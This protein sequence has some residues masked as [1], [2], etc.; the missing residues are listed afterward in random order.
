VAQRKP[1][2]QTGYM[3]VGSNIAYHTVQLPHSKEEIEQWIL[4]HALAAA[5]AASVDPYRLISPPVR[6]PEA[7]FDFTLRTVAGTEYLDLQEIVVLPKDACGYEDGRPVYDAEAMAEAVFQKVA[8]KSKH[9][10]KPRSS[11]HL[12]L[13]AT[14][15]RFCLVHSVVQH[16][17][18]FLV[19]RRHVFATVTYF[20]PDDEECGEFIILYP[21]PK[22]LLAE[23]EAWHYAARQKGSRQLIAIP[24]PRTA[25]LNGPGTVMFPNPLASRK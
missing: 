20:T 17:T 16:L 24:D 12:L 1:R 6:N 21:V 25:K 2:G 7:H 23:Y 18:L 8:R 14:D 4:N 5:G 9:Y 3:E 10:G 22:E 19:R 13:Y 15:W 11:V